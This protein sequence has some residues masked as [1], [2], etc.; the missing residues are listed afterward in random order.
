MMN[1][2]SILSIGHRKVDGGGL[3]GRDRTGLDCERRS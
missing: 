3:E 1:G 2:G